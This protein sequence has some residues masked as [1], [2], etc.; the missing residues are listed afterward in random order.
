[1][2]HDPSF[3]QPQLFRVG[4]KRLSRPLNVWEVNVPVSSNLR[5][6]LIHTP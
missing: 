4:L 2:I 3:A 6:L 5:P 1:M